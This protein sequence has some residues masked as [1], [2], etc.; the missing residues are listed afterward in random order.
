MGFTSDIA[1]FDRKQF[2]ALDTKAGAASSFSRLRQHEQDGRWI[3]RY[4]GW[5]DG[6]V[7]KAAIPLYRGRMRTWADPSYDPGS[8]GLPDGVGEECS[9][10]NSLLVGGCLDR[11]TGFHVDADA[12]TPER[13]RRLLVEAA[14]LA[15]DEDRCLLFP[16]LY[17]DARS[18]LDAATGDRV[19]WSELGR[20]AHLFGL[21]DPGWEA[22]LASKVRYRLRRDQRTIADAAMTA[23]EATWDEVGDWAS[24][25]IA[26]HNAAKGQQ[27][28]PEFVGFRLSTWQENPDIDVLVFT[29]E[30]AGLRGVQTVLLW[31]DELEVYEI[32]LAGEESDERFALYLNL[33]LHLP[34]RYARAR[35]ID[36]IRLGS[37]AETAK[38]RRGGVFE[39]L[40]GGVL[41]RAETRRLA[42]GEA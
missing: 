38:A 27:E 25:L 9:P 8:W 12:R 2:D 19:V 5:R 29:A 16:Y 39:P 20:E 18:A 3:T 21:A 14:G 35:G 32:G 10:R 42:R 13:L 30:A 41:G 34:I 23:G 4:L 36:H 26:D 15:A 17:G 11:R 7:L 22:G 37:K 1:D 28:L 24:Q 40:Y 33:L 6:D 31:G